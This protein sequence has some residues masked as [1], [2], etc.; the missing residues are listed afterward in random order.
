MVGF[1]RDRRC[2]SQTC[3]VGRRKQKSFALDRKFSF[4]CDFLLSCCQQIN[5][6]QTTSNPLNESLIQQREEQAL[7]KQRME[8]LKALET[9]GFCTFAYRWNKTHNAME[10]K[11]LYDYLSPGEQVTQVGISLAGRIKSK[12]TFGKLMFLTLED[13]SGSIQLYVEQQNLCSGQ[14]SYRCIKSLVDIGDIVGV[15]GWIKR[16][17]KGEL[18]IVVKDWQMLAKSLLPLPDKFHGLTDVAKRYRHRHLDM[19]VNPNVRQV[20]KQRAHIVSAIRELLERKHFVEVETPA[21]HRIAGGADAS[22]F[23]TYHEALDLQLTLRIATELFLKRCI[24]G[25]FEKVYEIGRVFRNEGISTRHNPEFTSLELYEAYKD[26]QDMMNLTEELIQTVAK[27]VC[28]TTEIVYMEERIQLGAPFRRVTMNDLVKETIGL[29]ILSYEDLETAKRSLAGKKIEGMEMESIDSLGKL[30]SSCFEHCCEKLLIQ[31][32]FVLDYPIE[33]S[34]LAKQHRKDPRLTERF[35]L[36]IAGRE[37]ANAFS[38]LN[39]P[40][41]QRERLMKQ[42]QGAE[43]VGK[44]LDEDFLLALEQGMPPTGGMGMGIDRLVMLLTN[45]SSIRQVIAFPLLK[46]E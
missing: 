38:E 25:G 36:Y 22:P 43:Q 12:R 16:T 31:P 40:I 33:I 14:D 9:A 41:E 17:D 34:P 45:S 19:I 8:K 20:L 13:D 32:T 11:T 6:S 42:L 23:V 7:K 21:L 10:L 1:K 46:P 29:D 4:R 44:E 27:Q 28:G 3:A 5:Q 26:Y 24:V 2:C 15:Q 30:L 18:S 37:L 39:D 35:E